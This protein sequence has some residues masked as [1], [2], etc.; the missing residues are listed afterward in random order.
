MLKYI[1][2]GVAAYLIYKQITGTE[3]P[4]GTEEV[5]TASFIP[6]LLPIKEANEAWKPPIAWVAPPK[7]KKPAES[8]PAETKKA[9][10]VY[11]SE[12]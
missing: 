8:A 12:K 4:T 7:K 11:H 3:L 2:A 5:S 1:I 9:I 10:T 6:A